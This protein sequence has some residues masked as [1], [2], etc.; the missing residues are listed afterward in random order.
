MTRFPMM[1]LIPGWLGAGTLLLGGPGCGDDRRLEEVERGDF[2]PSDDC[3]SS[4]GPTTG[5]DPH[6]K[7]DV[8]DGVGTAG[9]GGPPTSCGAAAA[10]LSSVGCEFWAVDLPN[11]WAHSIL[12]AADTAIPADQ[13]FSV[14]AANAS[15]QSAAMVEVFL[16]DEFIDSAPVSSGEI[17]VFDLPNLNIDPT[18][19]TATGRAYRIISDVPVAVY[20]FQPLDNDPPPFSN[21]ASLLF[22]THALGQDYVAVTSYATAMNIQGGPSYPVNIGSFVSIVAV[23][24]GTTVDTYPTAPLV[25][26]PSAGVTLNAG[27]VFTII[28]DGGGESGLANLSGTR[29]HADR[30]VAVFSGNV[31]A[32]EPVDVSGCCLDHL[33]HQL[34]P[35]SAWSTEYVI[36]PPPRYDG[37][38]DESNV[39]RILAAEDGTTLT[40]APGAPAGAPTQLSAGDTAEFRTVEPFVLTASAPISVAQFLQSNGTLDYNGAKPGDPAMWIT[41]PVRQFQSHYVFLSPPGYSDNFVTIT[42]RAGIGME[43]DGVQVTGQFYVTGELDGASYMHIHVPVSAGVHV[44]TAEEP[45]G[46][47]VFGYATDVSYAYPGGSGIKYFQPPPPPP[48]G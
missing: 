22:P 11:G 2:S 24:D 48:Q 46:I 38:V 12:S 4:A 33:E 31:A 18:T 3:G 7:Y 41:P 39:V 25:G 26:G 15:S 14:V 29:V 34:L 6:E 37:K 40:Y 8:S 19:T 27:E 35:M 1:T 21:D 45:V 16:G 5:G 20:Q 10:D 43:L 47:A 9:D 44:L 32:H 13:Q 30:P 42:N 36:S 17:H 28:G 23:E